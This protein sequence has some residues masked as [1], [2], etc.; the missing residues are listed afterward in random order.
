MG[1]N[2][3]QLPIDKPN[4]KQIHDGLTKKGKPSDTSLISSTLAGYIPSSNVF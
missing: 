2:A 3:V 1:L 4:R